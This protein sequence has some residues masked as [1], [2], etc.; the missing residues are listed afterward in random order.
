VLTLSGITQQG[1]DRSLRAALRGPLI[2]A[3]CLALAA[4]FLLAVWHGPEV[5]RPQP[6]APPAPAAA[7]PLAPPS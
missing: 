6:S 2:L 3:F 5:P 1:P 4:A 7:Q